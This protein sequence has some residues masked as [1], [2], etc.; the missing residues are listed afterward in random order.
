[1]RGVIRLIIGIVFGLVILVGVG[2][3]SFKN[4]RVNRK[5]AI[6]TM[7]EKEI[8]HQK[9]YIGK[10]SFT[11]EEEEMIEL[12]V[13]ELSYPIFEF[14]VDDSV[15]SMKTTIYQLRRGKWKTI[16]EGTR[17]I[18]SGASRIAFKF[19]D[20]ANGV[21]IKLQNSKSRGSNAY[22]PIDH[23]DYGKMRRRVEILN[24][25]KEV[26]YDQEIPLVI[27]L[28]SSKNR[29][30]AYDVEDFYNHPNDEVDEAYA[31]TILFS[32]QSVREVQGL[33]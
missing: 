17:I 25:N 30:N 2:Y 15:K 32:K 4:V 22:M 18:G 11:Q 20:I 14:N 8:A 3:I 12:L 29:M 33:S 27:Q 1:M 16:S 7:K 13:G 21:E 24:N 9:M 23:M 19:D 5:A 6:E 31:I 26:V 28:Y 10:A